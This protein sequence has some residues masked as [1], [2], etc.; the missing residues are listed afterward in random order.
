MATRNTHS[1]HTVKD[2]LAEEGWRFGP[3]ISDSLDVEGV[4]YS[5]MFVTADHPDGGSAAAV[6]A[7]TFHDL[8]KLHRDVLS[9]L[10]CQIAGRTATPTEEPSLTWRSCPESGLGFAMTEAAAKLVA[11]RSAALS[12]QVLSSWYGRPRGQVTRASLANSETGQGGEKVQIAL[13]NTQLAWEGCTETV[14][15]RGHALVPAS[16]DAPVLVGFGSG[17]SEAEADDQ[18]EADLA[19]QVAFLG[20]ETLLSRPPRFAAQRRYSTEML[21]H[22]SGRQLLL[23]WLTAFPTGEESG[24]TA[25]EGEAA[26]ESPHSVQFAAL[27]LFSRKTPDSGPTPVGPAPVDKVFRATSA[28]LLPVVYGRGFA[29]YEQLFRQIGWASSLPKF[30][31]LT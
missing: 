9:Q 19:T 25:D 23:D 4:R 29:P 5:R 16:T 1:E 10:F 8:A 6:C 22:P 15:S 31:P 26:S 30:H 28:T 12:H 3:P 11:A 2:M 21:L 7:S 27:P 14:F 13:P 18:A 20:G 24:E 17:S